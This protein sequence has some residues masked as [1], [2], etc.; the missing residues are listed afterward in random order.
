[1]ERRGLLVALFRRCLNKPL[2]LHKTARFLRLERQSVGKSKSEK[3]F[4]DEPVV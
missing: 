3:T 2:A 4:W 1:M